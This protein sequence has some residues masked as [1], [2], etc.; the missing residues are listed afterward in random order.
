M[1]SDITPDAIRA[2]SFR[3]AFRGHDPSEVAS[4]LEAVARRIEELESEHNKLKAQAADSVRADMATEFD[5]VGQEVSA[6][7]QTARAAA[8]SMRERASQEAERWR[9]EAQEEAAVARREA[10]ADAEALRRDA[11]VVGT[12]V[13]EQAQ[14]AAE[15]MRA[16]AERDVLTVMGE[17]ERE[18]HRLTSGSRREAEDLVRGANV[19]AERIITVAA[20]RRDEI[21]DGANRQAATA[22]ER[23]RAL[24][25]RREELLAELENVRSTLTRMEGSLEER[26]E[27]LDLAAKEPTS[28]RVVH[29]P[30]EAKQQWELGETV[31]VIQ[32]EDDE[33]Q[34]APP[35]AEE[36][37][38]EVAR[39]QDQEPIST[40]PEPSLDQPEP[41]SL[42]R[43]EPA[44]P[45]PDVESPHQ[46]LAR[47]EPESEPVTQPDAE[48][49]SQPQTQQQGLV[50]SEPEAAEA[51]DPDELDALFAA[52]RSTPEPETQDRGASVDAPVDDVPS[53]QEDSAGTDWIAMREASLIP[54]TNRG[55]RGVK[56][57]MTE[58]QNVALD[59]LRTEGDWRLEPDAIVDAI[60]ADLVTVWTESFSAG[61]AA[62]EQMA[63]DRLKR[64]DTPP[65][66][67][68]RRLADDLAAAVGAALDGAGEGSRERQSAVS[69]V[70]RVWRSDE[71]ERRLRD[72]ALLGYETGIEMSRSVPAE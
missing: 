70:F 36:M 46:T 41:Q 39:I 21:I 31:R 12:E 23:T 34:P 71:A 7:L 53:G 50:A 6:I 57:V 8:E 27:A 51:P 25:T 54:I 29:P 59:S 63:G 24:E 13:L 68:D 22:Q 11:W 14:T 9:S 52:L 3:T 33:D 30:A 1:T 61:H 32:P 56:K 43:D 26:K 35:S 47:A 48:P 16:E 69:K 72:L 42:G 55:L 17:A 19:E 37:R 49:A 40:P 38:D 66:T 2:A 4:L 44:R 62:A 45:D 18:A 58:M 28:V 20:A 5:R 60:H 65:L 10:H 64:P 67:E 15:A